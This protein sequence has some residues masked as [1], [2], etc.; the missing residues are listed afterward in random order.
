M[1]EMSIL[2][3]TGDIKIVWDP[4]RLDEVASA[5]AAFEAAKKKK[6]VAYS[7]SESGEADEIIRDFDPNAEKIIMRPAM[8]GG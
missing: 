4:H 7:V 1:S 5:K 6:M 3:R 8:V 2:D